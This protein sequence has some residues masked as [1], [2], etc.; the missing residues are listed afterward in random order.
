MILQKMTD[1]EL[2]RLSAL[3]GWQVSLVA[4]QTGLPKAL[5]ADVLL[6]ST[7]LLVREQ[8]TTI[9]PLDQYINYHCHRVASDLKAS[10]FDI[11]Q[12]FGAQVEMLV[13]APL[14]PRPKEKLQ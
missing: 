2:V 8:G 9:I 12:I 6:V 5:V 13:T 7:Y 10:Y 4:E 3:T 11:Q 14:Q 1:Q